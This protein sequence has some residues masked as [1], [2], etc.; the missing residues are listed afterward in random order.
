VID[1]EFANRLWNWAT[2]VGVSLVVAALAL[3]VIG[4]LMFGL[5][6]NLGFG[7]FVWLL[8]IP[9]LV[10]CA[11]GGAKALGQPRQSPN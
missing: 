7:P 11:V 5:S 2:K 6:N 3:F 4:L 9:G 1:R 10:F 8:G